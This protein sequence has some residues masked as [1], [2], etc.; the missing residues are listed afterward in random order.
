MVCT[1]THTDTHRHAKTRTDTHRHTAASKTHINTGVYMVSTVHHAL[2]VPGHGTAL[3]FWDRLQYQYCSTYIELCTLHIALCIGL[4][5]LHIALCGL[6]TGV[7]GVH[8]LSRRPVTQQW[9]RWPP[10]Y[11]SSSTSTS[12]T[13]TSTSS[14]STS[15]S[16][17]LACKEFLHPQRNEER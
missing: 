12:S 15:T 9:A 5:K 13:S 11:I 14:I 6:H 4:C 3:C 17:W 7:Y 8:S 1:Q 2:L 16:T 10:A